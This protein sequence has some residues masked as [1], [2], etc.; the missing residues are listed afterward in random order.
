MRWMMV[1][2]SL[3]ASSAL[4]GGV[5]G[6]T[7]ATATAGENAKPRLFVTEVKALDVPAAQAQAFTDAVV[8]TLSARGLF[9]V[10]AARDVETMLGVERQKSLVG[11][12]ESNPEQCAKDV[13]D[14]LAAPFVLSGQ[15]VKVGSAWQLTLQMLD[16]RRAQPVAR[17]TKLSGSLDELRQ[18]VPW[19][20]AEATG[21]PLPPPPSRVLPYSLIAAGGVAAFAGGA[22]GMLA[23]SRQQVLNDELCPGGVPTNGQCAGTNLRDRS[24]YQ[25]QD[26]ELG[27]Q[28]WIAGG[29]LAGGALLVGAGL[30]LNPPSTQAGQVAVRVVPTG[31][32]VMFAGVF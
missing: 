5:T 19:A 23:L 14:S 3:V 10:V 29:L 8:A 9:E 6:A 11:L 1:V 26:Q 22:L 4:A 24:F 21:S 16:T 12:C 20:A 13:S 25:A 31:D 18:L 7:P 2:L 28:K 32:G 17:S 27:R 15:L 30:F